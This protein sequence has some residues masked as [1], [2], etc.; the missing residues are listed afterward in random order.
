[1]KVK[2][3]K[4]LSV[5]GAIGLFPTLLSQAQIAQARPGSDRLISA[6]Q[7]N[8]GGLY[9]PNGQD[10]FLKGQERLETEVQR[11]NHP[12]RLLSEGVLEVSP[13]VNPEIQ[14]PADRRPTCVNAETQTC[15]GSRP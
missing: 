11:L 1:M 9:R 12:Q 13:E 5:C 14:R 6:P 2:L 4:V 7:T 3:I 10:F 15:G 8:L